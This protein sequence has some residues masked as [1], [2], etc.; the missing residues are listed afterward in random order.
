MYHSIN[1]LGL[2]LSE[3][4]LELLQQRRALFQLR[5]IMRSP[6]AFNAPGATKV[7]P[8][9]SE[10]LPATQVH[11]TALLFIDLNL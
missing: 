10:T 6:H 11:D 8:E 4:L 5:R 3:Y 1:R 7:K 9:K 2:M